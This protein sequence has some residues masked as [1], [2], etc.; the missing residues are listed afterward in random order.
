MCLGVAGLLGLGFD[1]TDLHFVSMLA[2]EGCL[3]LLG[4]GLDHDRGDESSLAGRISLAC[5]VDVMAR[6][7]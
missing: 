4:L 1:N 5:L 7:K 3:R 2:L 6:F